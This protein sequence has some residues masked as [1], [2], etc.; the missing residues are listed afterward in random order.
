MRYLSVV[1]APVY[2]LVGTIHLLVVA[3]L[4]VTTGFLSLGPMSRPRE[5]RMSGSLS[6]GMAG[7][8]QGSVAD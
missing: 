6:A 1:L 2:P 7:R 3:M 5:G 8:Q 4:V